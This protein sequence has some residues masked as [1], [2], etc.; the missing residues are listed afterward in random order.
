MQRYDQ[1]YREIGLPENFI[2]SD[3]SNFD[4]VVFPAGGRIDFVINDLEGFSY[5]KNKVKHSGIY[6]RCVG[7]KATRVLNYSDNQVLLCFVCWLFNLG[8]VGIVRVVESCA[9]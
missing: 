3:N 5:R 6:L 1:I 7:C 8:S 9:I 4:V 2:L